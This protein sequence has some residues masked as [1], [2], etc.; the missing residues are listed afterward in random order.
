MRPAAACAPNTPPARAPDRE[1]TVQVQRDQV[2][3]QGLHGGCMWQFRG[4]RVIAGGSV[5]QRGAV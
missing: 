1:V 2:E 5:G 4:C 3:L